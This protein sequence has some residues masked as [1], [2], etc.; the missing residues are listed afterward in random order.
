MPLLVGRPLDLA[1]APDYLAMLRQHEVVA[2]ED[3]RRQSIVANLMERFDSTRTRA[4]LDHPVHLWNRNVGLLSLNVARPHN[5]TQHERDSLSD[6]A[7]HLSLILKEK[8][9]QD[10]RGKTEENM[11]RLA[12]AVEQ[13]DESIIITDADA[14]I[15]YV[16]PAFERISGFASLDVLGRTPGFLKSG[17]HDD[18]FYKEIWT[19]LLEGRVWSG[20]MMN[21]RK[22]GS[23]YEE[24]CSISPVRNTKGVIENFVAIKRDVTHEME[25]ERMLRQSQKMEALGTLAGGIAHDF[26]NIL[27]S[28][29]GFADM[30]LEE[31][32]SDNFVYRCLMEVQTAGNRAK[33]LVSQILA[34]SRQTEQTKQPVK[35][36][37]VVKETIRL[38]RS[39]IPPS[40]H[41]QP[42]IDPKCAPV[43]AD[44][45]Q[46]HQIVMNLCTNAYHAMRNCS[47]TM[48]IN[49]T[50]VFITEEMPG[51]LE[52]LKPGEHV[53][54]SVSDTGHGMD[55]LT[56][57]RIFEPYYT[58][59][60][61]GEG[62]G[63]GL[64]TVQSIAKSHNAAILVTSTLGEGSRFQVYFPIHGES[65]VPLSSAPVPVRGN[66]E[67]ILFVDDEQS[68]VRL[69]D[70]AL[71]QL[72]Y[73]VYAYTNPREALEAFQS[74]PDS[75][76]VL[77]TDLV[78]PLISGEELI[79]EVLL[80]RPNIPVILFTGNSETIAEGRLQELRIRD[81]LR[82]PVSP[83]LLTQAINRVLANE[84]NEVEG[85]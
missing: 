71:R 72:N 50:S 43:L 38:L 61:L 33:D 13:A 14:Y 85:N 78:M 40:I 54:L 57:K 1:D 45:T 52:M 3:V 19:T 25:M 47:G 82:K 8:H 29:I 66:R 58:T 79:R 2:L 39:T 53:V 9:A 6:I 76:D 11:R 73:E 35:L 42:R 46:V 24:E 20:H 83:A 60:Q 44:P 5:W 31:V 56:L 81:F 84:Q 28:I 41:I 37:T 15:Q 70:A 26:N 69:A 32:D 18:A 63:L 17:H 10:E 62:T 30:A 12:T 67:R 16:N 59:K 27:Q 4:I 77:I 34:F 51:L 55:E 21:R 23:M 7:M 80:L 49:L 65:N 64:A 22:D 75:F 68:V 74:S 36:Q 48:G